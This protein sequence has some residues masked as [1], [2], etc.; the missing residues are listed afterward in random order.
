M[1]AMEH[2]GFGLKYLTVAPDGYSPETTYPLII[3]LHG[4]GANMQD[5]AGMA[6]MINQ[7][8]YVYACPNAPLAFDLGGG[9]AGWGWM[10]PRGMSTPEQVQSAEDLLGWLLRRGVRPVQIGAGESSPPGLFA[11]RRHDLQMRFRAA[12]HFCRAGC[13]ERN[14]CRTRTCWPKSFPKTASRLSSSPTACTTR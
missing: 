9:H 11:G 8:G 1:Q 10:A 4:F 3:M 5:L 12:H 7:H 14:P 13:I 6:P 2:Q